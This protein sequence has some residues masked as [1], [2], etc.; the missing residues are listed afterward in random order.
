MFKSFGVAHGRLVK[1]FLKF[2]TIVKQSLD[3]GYEFVGN[4]DR[5]SSSLHPDIQDMAGVLFPLQAR[6]AVLPDAG[7]PTETQRA[8]SR[9]PEIYGT[10]SEPLFYVGSRFYFSWHVV[11]MPHG[12]R[13]VKRILSNAANAIA[14]EFRDRN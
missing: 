12:I 11:C 9:R 10:I 5:E 3:V 13:T 8:Q 2:A 1:Q 6:L 4:I 7:T 14:Y